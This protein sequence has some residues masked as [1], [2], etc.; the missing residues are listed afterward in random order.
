MEPPGDINMAINLQLQ[1]ALE[2]LQWASLQP[3]PL[4]PSTVHQGRAN[5]NGPEGSTLN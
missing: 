2:W 5:I 4:S 3:P 1:G